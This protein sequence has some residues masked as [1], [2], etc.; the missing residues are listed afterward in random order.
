MEE[1]NEG[2]NVELNIAIL[3]TIDPA[4]EYSVYL[5]KPGGS[6]YY[7]Y[8]IENGEILIEDINGEFLLTSDPGSGYLLHI[9]RCDTNIFYVYEDQVIFCRT[10]GND[11]QLNGQV[12]VESA[13]NAEVDVN[14]ESFVDCDYI[15]EQVKENYIAIEEFIDWRE[16]VMTNKV[17]KFKYVEKYSIAESYNDSIQC[18]LLDNN[19]NV[20]FSQNLPNSYGINLQEWNLDPLSLAVGSYYHFKVSGMNKGK[21]YTIRIRYD[22]E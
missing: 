3:N 8:K 19:R 5:V 15:C 18:Q 2:E 22:G 1:F 17:I 4:D 7:G 6:E 20:L 12:M 9:L 14:I 21:E 16:H 10:I 13:I 11:F